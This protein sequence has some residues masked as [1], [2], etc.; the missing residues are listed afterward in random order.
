MSV[1]DFGEIIRTQRDQFKTPNIYQY[2]D[3]G[4][5]EVYLENFRKNQQDQELFLFFKFN[6]TYY[7]PLWFEFRS[8]NNN[9][10]FLLKE[11]QVTSFTELKKILASSLQKEEHYKT[12]FKAIIFETKTLPPHSI[13]LDEFIIESEDSIVVREE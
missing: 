2:L 7:F 1:S 9:L 13:V 11:Y 12:T 10:L 3:N 5:V 6:N 8:I 4:I